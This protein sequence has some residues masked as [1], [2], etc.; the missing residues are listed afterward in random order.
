MYVPLCRP[1][2]LLGVVVVGGK[3]RRAVFWQAGGSRRLP[4][5]DV[6]PARRREYN[7]GIKLVSQSL[8]H[9]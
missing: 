8:E 6:P 9:S 2:K 7:N 3:R 1:R 5:L 4:E